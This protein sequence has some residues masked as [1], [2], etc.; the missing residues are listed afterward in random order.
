[1]FEQHNTSLSTPTQRIW[2]LPETRP[3]LW[4]ILQNNRPDK[5]ELVGRSTKMSTVLG[6]KG[7]RIMDNVYFLLHMFL[8]F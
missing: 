2:K 1:M 6:I 5:A 8:N 4:D 3:R 7:D